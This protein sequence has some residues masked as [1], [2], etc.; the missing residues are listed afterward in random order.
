MAQRLDKSIT[1]HKKQIISGGI[2]EQNKQK[3]ER[4]CKLSCIIISDNTLFLRP[5]CLVY[6]SL[7]FVAWILAVNFAPNFS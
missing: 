6:I 4:N 1:T 3:A 2:I 5:L 7:Y